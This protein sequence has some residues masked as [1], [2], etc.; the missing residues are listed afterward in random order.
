MGSQ[1]LF[2][3]NTWKPIITYFDI[4]ISPK[5]SN[6]MYFSL[7]LCPIDMSLIKT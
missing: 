6:E 7:N 3:M 4:Y 2:L 5:L 1:I